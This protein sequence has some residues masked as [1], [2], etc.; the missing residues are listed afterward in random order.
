MIEHVTSDFE[1]NVLIRE[2][3]A[4]TAFVNIAI[5]HAM[6]M[7][8]LKTCIGVVISKQ[9]ITWDQ[10]CIHL[11]LLVAI[12]KVDKQIFHDLYEALVILFSND[13]VMEQVSECTT[14]IDFENLIYSNIS[15][16]EE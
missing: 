10:Q 6:E 2:K 13:Q 11:V 8:A 5:P 14:F 7:E 12:N 16:H 15:Y 3:A 9:G 4:S 1:K